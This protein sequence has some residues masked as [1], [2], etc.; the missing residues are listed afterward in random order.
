MGP[1]QRQKPASRRAPKSPSSK[2]SSTRGDSKL[3]VL[4]AHAANP[5]KWEAD[6]IA[7]LQS[8]DAAS[9]SSGGA[10]GPSDENEAPHSIFFF[11]QA[12]TWVKKA[13][14]ALKGKSVIITFHSSA[15]LDACASAYALAGELGEQAVVAPPDRINSESRR[16]LGEQAKAW[17][18]FSKA[19]AAH[20]HA[21]VILLDAND[22]SI[23]PQFKREGGSPSKPAYSPAVDILIDHHAPQGG[24]VSSPVA[25]IDP[26]ASSTCELAAHFVPRPT[27]EQARA[28]VLGILSDSA[29]LVRADAETFAVLSR[30]LRE[31]PQSYEQLLTELEQPASPASRAAVLEGLRQTAWL[32]EGS[33]VVATATVASHEAH[34]ADA[35]V[36]S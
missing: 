10:P 23:L 22:P 26:D 11:R 1:V 34:V 14:N 32:N 18:L 25:W 21:P 20:P 9:A 24:S 5:K 15:D 4:Q 13:L 29:R 31:C 28:L 6:Q 12:P 2:S 7:R 36:R 19:R 17:P 3:A 30:L 16:L 33:W 27:A 35:L 8:P